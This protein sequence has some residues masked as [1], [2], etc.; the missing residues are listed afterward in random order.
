MPLLS[1]PTSSKRVLFSMATTDA[2]VKAV[3]GAGQPLYIRQLALLLVNNDAS[4]LIPPL[5]RELRNILGKL[6]Q[7]RRLYED[8]HHRWQP[9]RP[10]STPH[11]T[12]TAK[13]THS[14]AHQ[15]STPT[16]QPTPSVAAPLTQS[17]TTERSAHQTAAT[18]TQH[19][20]SNQTAAAVTQHMSSNQTAPTT[21]QQIPSNQTA[22]AVTQHASSIGANQIPIIATQHMTSIQ[23][24]RIAAVVTPSSINRS[25]RKPRRSNCDD[26]NSIRAIKDDR[27][28]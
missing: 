27:I 25:H 14:S 8:Q 23:A 11:Q 19:I 22:G 28:P 20:P 21:T 2:V 18:T 9:Y 15:I 17:K 13:S 12:S 4:Q 7:E 10:K 26:S 1:H 24:N 3:V 6:R 16:N 5:F